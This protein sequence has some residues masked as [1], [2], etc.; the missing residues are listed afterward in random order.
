MLDVG[1][2]PPA[3]VALDAL[4]KEAAVS[5]LARGT[6]QPGRYL[7]LFGGDVEATKRAFKR[8]REACLEHLADCVLLAHADERIAPAA[9]APAPRWPAGIAG[10]T[11][12]VLQTATSP[13]LL[14]SVDRALKGAAV[15]LVQL[16]V[17]D[18][19]G[20]RAIALLWGETADV[21]AALEL[22]EA[23]LAQGKA[24]GYHA[25]IVRNADPEVL[26]AFESGTGFHKVWRG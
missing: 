18:G 6:V 8:G 13:T 19:L 12:G 5:V 10:D 1:A 15:D 26:G 16:R 2:V 3:L 21:E 20:G 11:L 4:A 25:A 24:A 14:R 9:L 22:S 7:I 17:A 23:A